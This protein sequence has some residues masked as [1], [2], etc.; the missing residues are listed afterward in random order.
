MSKCATTLAQASAEADGFI[1]HKHSALYAIRAARERFDDVA[2]RIDGIV[3]EAESH[4]CKLS[5]ISARITDVLG[6]SPQQCVADG[7]WDTQIHPDDRTRVAQQRAAAIDH[8]AEQVMEYR[9]LACDGRVVWLRDAFKLGGTAPMRVLRGIL[10]DISRH[11]YAEQALQFSDSLFQYC[12][13]SITVTDGALRIQRVNLAFTE[14]TGYHA[15]KIRGKTPRVLRSGVQDAGFYDA[16]WKAIDEHG[17]WRGEL[18]NRR[19]SGDLYIQQLSIARICDKNGEVI[20]YLGVAR[21]LSQSKAA[22]EHMEQL[23]YA[24][25]MT[26]L[27]NRAHLMAQLQRAVTTAHDTGSRFALLV[28]DI[29]RLSYINDTLGH[30]VGDQLLVAVA[31]RLRKTVRDAGS[32]S[33]HIGDEF[34]VLVENTTSP[35]DAAALAECVLSALGKP[36]ALDGH[37]IVVSTCVGISRYPQDGDT[38]EMLL[39]HADIALHDAK[40]I[41]ANQFRFFHEE[42]KDGALQRMRIESSLRQALQRNE[43][44]VYYQPQVDFGSGQICGMEALLRWSH[45]DMGFVSPAQFIPIAEKNGTI[46]EIGLWLTEQACME[47]RRLHQSG[48]PALRVAINVSAHQLAHDDFTQQIQQILQQTRLPPEFLEL[49]LTESMIMQRP[50]RVVAILNELRALGVQFSIDDFGTGYSSLSQLK[51]FPIDKLKIDQSFT[52]DIGKDDNGAAI[53]R[54]IIALGK[55]MGLRV[56]AEGVETEAQKSFLMENGCDG[57]QGYLVSHP[58]PAPNFTELLASHRAHNRKE[59]S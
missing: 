12:T 8:A 21:D 56:I 1:D 29:D 49:E 13:D 33:R 20:N 44:Q 4:T 43:F 57:M 50:E 40:V 51:R 38:P 54:T 9:M 30:Q 48:Y 45:P 37:D 22:E 59:T 27:P 36:F 34:T 47:T 42:M 19:K 16:M 7:F 23:A 52:C 31:E 6:Y 15:D 58:V 24:D 17:Y 35:G 18:W 32:V 28:V 3:W 11:K 53:T 26:G 14:I 41:G 39:K 55:G 25:P 5:F 10:T 2:N 46:I